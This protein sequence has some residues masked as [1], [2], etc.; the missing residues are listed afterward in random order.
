MDNSL[1]INAK[2]NPFTYQEMLQPVL[3]ATQAQQ[4]IEDQYADLDTKANVWDQVTND[5]RE[6][7]ARKLYE[8]YTN[9]LHDQVNNLV[10]NGLTPT[11]RSKLA[12]LKSRYTKEISPIEMAYNKRNELIKNQRELQEK[13]NTVFFNKNASDYT[14]S[15]FI[16]NGGITTQA[17]SGKALEEESMKIFENLKHE[18]RKDPKAWDKILGGQYF[19]NNKVE[20]FSSKELYNTLA[21]TKEGSQLINAMIDQITNSST[22]AQWGDPIAYMKAR[23]AVEKGVWSAVGTTDTKTLENKNYDYYLKHKDD[24]KETPQL[25]YRDVPNTKINPVTNTTQL[26]EDAKY[27]NDIYRTPKV[28]DVKTTKT[29][30]KNTSTI[31]G[32]SGSGWPGSNVSTETTYYPYVERLEEIMKRNN[33]PF[34]I[35]KNKDGSISGSPENAK[36]LKEA[37]MKMQDEIKKSAVR[38]FTSKLNMTKYD[39]AKEYIQ[40]NTRTFNTNT[41]TTGL[42]EFKDG[43]KGKPIDISKSSKYFNDQFDI[44]Y[45]PKVG[46]VLNTADKDGTRSAVIDPE[47]I[48][49]PNDRTIASYTKGINEAINNKDYKEASKMK[50]YLMDHLYYKFNNLAK[51]QGQV[52]SSKQEK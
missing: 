40:Q 41:G 21:K 9:D 39:L 12:S 5:P 14:I 11:S 13:D 17:Q 30:Y 33:I 27:L 28:L 36:I 52:L 46:I 35:K 48:D 43:K 23:R 3:M 34:N 32:I 31:P 18:V 2:Y 22:A 15:D 45:N 25:T 47:L 37:V 16:K 24:V 44:D 49:D 50:A 26:D 1:I 4:N 42:Y 19:Q 29:N 20:G 51:V 10:Q 38:D 6:T 8:G 7:Y